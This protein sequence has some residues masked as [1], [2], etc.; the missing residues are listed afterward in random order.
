MEHLFVR[1]PRLRLLLVNVH[2]SPEGH[3][4]GYG[5]MLIRMRRALGLGRILH[6]RVFF[7]PSRHALNTAITSLQSDDPV[8]VSADSWTARALH[9]LWWI[10]APFRI[11]NPL[12]WGKIRLDPPRGRAGGG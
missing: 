6:A 12:L 4:V 9:V 11:G 10:A 2:E 8:I 7:V 1:I 5:M 3:G